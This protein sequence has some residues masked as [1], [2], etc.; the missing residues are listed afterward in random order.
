MALHHDGQL[1]AYGTCWN[2]VDFWDPAT[3]SFRR[4]EEGRGSI[5]NMA[6]TK[7]GKQLVVVARGMKPEIQNIDVASG[8]IVK[9]TALGKIYWTRIAIAANDGTVALCL[10]PFQ[11]CLY[12]ADTG[13]QR[14]LPLSDK[15]DFVDLSFSTDARTLLTMSR[16]TETVWLWDVVKGTLIRRLRLPGL[17]WAN[18][19]SELLISDDRTTLAS[20]EAFSLLRIWD[21]RTGQ[22]RF[23]VPQHVFA[24]HLTFSFDGKEVISHG[25]RGASNDSEI[26]RWDTATGKSLG[27]VVPVL[28]GD[29]FENTERSSLFSP[30]GTWLAQQVASTIQLH[31]TKSGK[32]VTLGNR[33]S[34]DTLACFSPDGRIL[35]TTTPDRKVRLW[36]TP[37]GKLQRQ[38][39]LGKKTNLISW[40]HLMPDNRRLMTV[41]G[42]EKVQFWESATGKLLDSLPLRHRQEGAT[43]PEDSTDVV[44]TPDGR[45]LLMRNSLG[46]WMW[47][48]VSQR[49][50]GL[51]EEDVYENRQPCCRHPRVSPDGRLL[52]WY[53]SNANLRLSEIASGKIIHRFEDFYWDAGFSPTG[54]RLA[55][56]CFADASILIWDIPSLFRSLVP[57]HPTAK[58]DD[59]WADMGS[60]SAIKA[61]RALWRLASLPEADLFLSRRLL[62]VEA[63]PA[64]R[65][66]TPIAELGS[67][68]FTTREKAERTLREIGEAAAEALRK[69]HRNTTDLEL[70]RR[71]E[72]LLDQL[73]ARAP[74]RLRE[75]RAVLALEARGTPAAR[76]LLDRL[77][78]GLPGARLTQEANAA[79]KRLNA[80]R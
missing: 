14:C 41:E 4:A 60:T 10:H 8:K 49:E 64:D 80:G 78:T 69:A 57:A 43:K 24:A 46:L 42:C 77:A 70:R 68:D 72:R 33:D 76:K 75:A 40:I 29:R 61:H 22:P 21:A 16:R 71:V 2:D 27:K 73:Q 44:L 18:E 55:T 9:R 30:G 50:V 37:T 32:C 20:A 6:F 11:L 36:D 26:Y 51:F 12:D 7:D 1:A 52:V 54:W 28:T 56:S 63:I 48:S 31:D 58:P 59:L 35:A 3:N 47:D 13:K 74:E 38:L 15:V 67:A 62:S 65:V 53:D 34:G 25:G 23:R 45:Y 19:H 79:L 66:H 17:A 39:E 5:E